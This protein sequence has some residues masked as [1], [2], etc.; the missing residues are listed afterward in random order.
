MSSINL[1]STHFISRTSHGVFDAAAAVFW[2]QLLL[3]LL[4]L[5]LLSGDSSKMVG[6][7]APSYVLAWWFYPELFMIPPIQQ[8]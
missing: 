1:A 6:S 3:P 5:L 8:Q 2:E 7:L 4:L